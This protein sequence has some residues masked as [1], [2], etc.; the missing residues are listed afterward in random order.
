MQQKHDWTKKQAASAVVP[1]FG[2]KYIGEPELLR[3]LG[4]KISGKKVLELGSG[5][6]YWLELLTKH[7]A[8]CTGVEISERQLELARKTNSNIS[9]I[10]GDATSL[11]KYGLKKSSFDIVLLEHVLLEIPSIQKIRSIMTGAFD[12]LK[13]QGVIIISEL[14]PS[15]PSSRPDNMK[16]APEYNYFSSGK[17][18]EVV[19]KRVDGGE[20][21]Y[22]DFHWTLADIS[23]SLTQA[24]FHIV[25]LTEPRPTRQLAKQY[26]E[27][28]Y[29]LTIPMSL[30]IKAIKP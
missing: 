12:L 8:Q 24:G 30:W 6:G 5:N 16:V 26:P 23:G 13:K 21:V 11:E 3:M 29:R 20:T 4:T 15:A 28:S 9:Y 10:Q 14:H 18:I 22:K 17:V 2:K 7:G 27:L 1:N 19:S 25:E